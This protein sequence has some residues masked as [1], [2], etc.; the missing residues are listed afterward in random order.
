M[1]GEYMHIKKVY[2]YYR[3]FVG[4]GRWGG[5]DGMMMGGQLGRSAIFIQNQILDSLL[6]Y[7]I[8]ILGFN[9]WPRRCPT[10]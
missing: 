1:F 2:K 10:R 3:K 6:Y 9:L 8:A 4:G 5:Y 7:L